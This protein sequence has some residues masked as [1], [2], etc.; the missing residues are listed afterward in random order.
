MQ[1][2]IARRNIHLS[3][4]TV[5]STVRYTGGSQK[6]NLCRPTP[7][8]AFSTYSN[9]VHIAWAW[10]LATERSG[11]SVWLFTSESGAFGVGGN[12]PQSA[13]LLTRCFSCNFLATEA[14]GH[15]GLLCTCS[16]G[17]TWLG[18]NEHLSTS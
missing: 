15:F 18:V 16:K 13:T 7:Q 4:D 10:A 9:G 6:D 5:A 17:E 14:E 11:H 8:D 3:K 1:E 2:E 12:F